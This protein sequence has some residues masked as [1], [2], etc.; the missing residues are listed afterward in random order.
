VVGLRHGGDLTGLALRLGLDEGRLIDFSTSTNPFGPPPL[1]LTDG[2]ALAPCRYPELDGRTLRGALGRRL[3]VDED[4][5]IVGNG[6]AELL[7][8]LIAYL[9]P[10]RGLIVEP[11]FSDYRRALEGNEAEVLSVPLKE[12]DDFRVDWSRLQRTVSAVDLVVLGQPNNPTGLTVDTERLTAFVADHSSVRFV[13]DEAFID[14]AQGG[15]SMV[16]EAISRSNVVVL[17]SLTKLYSIPN[18]RLGYLVAGLRRAKELAAA[19]PPWPLGQRQIEVAKL[20][21]EHESFPADSLRRLADERRFLLNELAK[22]SWLKV[23]PTDA[24][25][26][27]LKIEHPAFDSTRL[28]EAMARRGIVVRDCASFDR[29]GKRFIRLAVRSRPDNLGLI[30]VLEGIEG[31]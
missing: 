9:K 25:F 1:D 29:L 31:I 10:N 18:L 19:R 24:N 20:A 21:L 6:S 17:R 23:F 30:K 26:L 14:F 12:A 4:C 2:G 8:W 15:R 16:D 22:V 28:M 3:G 5:I 7:Y 13:I 27:L 11:G